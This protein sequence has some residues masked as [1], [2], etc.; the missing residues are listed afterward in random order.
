M[1]E[2]RER[3]RKTFV[4]TGL[5]RNR[6]NCADFEH[7]KRNVDKLWKTCGEACTL[8]RGEEACVRGC[9]VCTCAREGVCVCDPTLGATPRYP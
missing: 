7:H 3:D 5:K 6:G 4:G 9:G 8:S 1:I 2:G